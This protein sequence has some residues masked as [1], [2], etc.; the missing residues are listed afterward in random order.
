MSP[1]SKETE[2]TREQ[3]HIQHHALEKA[4]QVER[5]QRLQLEEALNTM[6]EQARL[7][8]ENKQINLQIEDDEEEIILEASPMLMRSEAGYGQMVWNWLRVRR[9]TLNRLMRMRPGIRKIIWGYFLLLHLL[10]IGFLFGLL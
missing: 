4:L 5:E 6:Q 10:V 1:Q 3:L 2:L 7:V 8:A 9:R